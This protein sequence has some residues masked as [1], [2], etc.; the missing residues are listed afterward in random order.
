LNRDEKAHL[1][2]VATNPTGDDDAIVVVSCTSLRGA[3]DQT[4]ILRAGEHPFIRWDMC[5][6]YNLA[7]VTSVSR[8]E[9]LIESGSAQLR[10][11]LALKLPADV[12]AGFSAS[13]FTKKRVRD[14]VARVKSRPIPTSATGG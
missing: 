10:E 7:E 1:W 9:E 3:K 13:D 6:A 8:V 2:V 14:F 12:V 11:P 4:V 5:L